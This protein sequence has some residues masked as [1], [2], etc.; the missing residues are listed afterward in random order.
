MRWVD[1]VTN[2]MDVNLSK[3]WVILKDGE[4]GHAAVHGVGHELATEQP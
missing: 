1:S 2:S 3:F 4:T